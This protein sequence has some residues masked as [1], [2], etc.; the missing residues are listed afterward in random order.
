MFD[1]ISPC[2]DRMNRVISA[3]LDGRWRRAMADRL[4]PRAG[5]RLLDLATGTGDQLLAA[6]AG[7]RVAEAVGLD[8][9]ERMLEVGRAKLALRPPPVPVRL[10]VG[11]ATAIPEPDQSFD[12]VTISFGIRNVTDV[13]RALREMYRVLKPGGRLLVLESSVPAWAPVRA[14]YLF[15]IRHVMPRLAGWLSGDG[16]AY[17]YL[18]VTMEQ[19]PHGAAFCQLMTDAG[20]RSVRAHP[21]CLGSVSIYQGDRPEAGP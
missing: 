12:A 15:Y 13:P 4:P 5:L 6:V 3:G 9:A 16:E 14:A 18:N 21:R 7:G 8:L 19:F 17:R 1:R 20:F 10:G 11:D 2:Y